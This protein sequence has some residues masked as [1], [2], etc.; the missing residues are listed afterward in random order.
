M[1]IVFHEQDMID[2]VCVFAA[3]RHHREPGEF[4]VELFFEEGRG[5][6]AEATVQHGFHKLIR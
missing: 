1:K 3:S 6:A 4:R 2:A 5:F